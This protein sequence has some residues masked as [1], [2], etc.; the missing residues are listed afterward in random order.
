MHLVL[1]LCQLIKGGGAYN[2]L[3]KS[4]AKCLFTWK[5]KPLSPLISYYGMT[6]HD[7][8]ASTDDVNDPDS[9]VLDMEPLVQPKPR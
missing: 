6:S 5:L 2:I 7:V 4:N 9:D 1:K 8:D 3:Q